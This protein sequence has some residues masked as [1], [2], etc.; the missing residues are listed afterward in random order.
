MVTP[1]LLDL[2]PLEA[3]KTTVVV[4]VSDFFC[5]LNSLECG[6]KRSATPPWILL[7]RPKA[8]SR[9]A[10]RRTPKLPQAFD[11]EIAIACQLKNRQLFIDSRIRY[12]IAVFATRF[13]LSVAMSS[14]TVLHLINLVA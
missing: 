4:G 3:L 1:D 8:A 2:V 12:Q 14:S 6:G 11:H 5:L 7:R 13:F 10:C 9:S